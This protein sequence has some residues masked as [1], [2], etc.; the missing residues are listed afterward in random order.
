[1]EFYV[2]KA[3]Q[4]PY[5]PD[6]VFEIMHEFSVFLLKDDK[7]DLGYYR[8]YKRKGH[9]YMGRPAPDHPG[10]L[11]HWQ[12]GMAGLIMAQLG[13]LI[14][15]ARNAIT[16]PAE[17]MEESELYDESTVIDLPS[18]SVSEEEVET[19]PPVPTPSL[20]EQEQEEIQ[21]YTLQEEPESPK[22]TISLQ[23]IQSLPPLAKL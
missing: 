4:L 5:V 12:I 6:E 13:G 8:Y 1:M 16:N 21:E 15:L 19:A 18:S 11:H 10:M 3:M 17:S 2:I 20:L 14:N 7:H 22:P 23:T 9:Y